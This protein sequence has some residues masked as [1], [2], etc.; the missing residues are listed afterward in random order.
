[1]VHV[2]IKLADHHVEYLIV[3][4]ILDIEPSPREDGNRRPV[5]NVH[6]ALTETMG[7]FTL[8]RN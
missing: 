1:M 7:R 8:C 2:F 4:I 3:I 5:L 6:P